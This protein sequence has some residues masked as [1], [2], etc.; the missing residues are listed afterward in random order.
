LVLPLDVVI[1][2][3]NVI[4]GISFKFPVSVVSYLVLIHLEVVIIS[5]NNLNVIIRHFLD[6][7]FLLLN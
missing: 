3:L 5:L 1:V 6:L 2:E 7:G 4:F